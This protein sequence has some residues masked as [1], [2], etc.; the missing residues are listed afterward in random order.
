MA[1]I[2]PEPVLLVNGLGQA[3]CA[4]LTLGIRGAAYGFISL[5]QELKELVDSIS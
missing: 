3:S 1:C 2:G 4:A 5:S